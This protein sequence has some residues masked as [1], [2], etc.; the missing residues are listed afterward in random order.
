[1]PTCGWCGAALGEAA[2]EPAKV[3]TVGVHEPERRVFGVPPATGLL[4]LGIA[5]AALAFFLLFT[6]SVLV[7]ALLLVLGLTILAGFPG[8]ARRPD[9][10]DLTRRAVRSYDGLRGRADATIETLAARAQ[11]RRQVRRIDSEVE[12][13]ERSRSEAVVQLGEAAYAED[14]AGIER[15]RGELAAADSALAAKRAERDA[16]L[17]ETEERVGDAQLRAQ[18]TERLE[19]DAPGDE[20]A[21]SVTADP[22]EPPAA[23]P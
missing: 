20:A 18:P 6:G 21:P 11:A 16:I 1:M 5:V 3:G 13:L 2:S 8:V 7:G 9:E 19:R 22:D 23:K 10:S 15:L 17:A 4:L 12:Q 14:A